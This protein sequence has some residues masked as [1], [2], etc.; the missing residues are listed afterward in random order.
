MKTIQ[1]GEEVMVSDPCYTV[2]TWCQ[3]KVKNV[4]PGEYLTT[5]LKSDNTG[6]WGNRCAA[7]VAV[8]KDY[9]EDTLSWR[10]D[11]TADIGVDSGQA[12][13]FSMETYRKD[14]IFMEKSG[15]AFVDRDTEGDHWYGHMCDR[16][17]SDLGWG[18]Y[19]HGVVSSSGF[20]DGS[21]RLLV[22]KHNGKIV[23]L[24]IDFFVLKLKSGDFDLIKTGEFAE[25]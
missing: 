23:G 9:Q 16:T 24:A 6:G 13:I 1:L 3:H 8:H 15:F 10:T 11:N 25:D 4:L 20:G 12:G 17:L 2:P 7:L 14:D 18:T 21:Y 5:V 22:A 19:S